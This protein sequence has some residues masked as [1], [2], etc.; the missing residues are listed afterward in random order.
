MQEKMALSSGSHPRHVEVSGNHYLMLTTENTGDQDIHL[1]R[2]SR[3]FEIAR[4]KTRQYRGVITRVS[5]ETV[6]GP[7][8][9]SVAHNCV[10]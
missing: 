2:V 9:S 4:L 8:Q 3:G 6:V 7:R 5:W 1:W 10:C